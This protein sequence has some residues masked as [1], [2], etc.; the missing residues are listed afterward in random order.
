M[1]KTCL[2]RH[3]CSSPALAQSHTC[4]RW[5]HFWENRH[6]FAV[7]PGVRHERVI[8]VSDVGFR[9]LITFLSLGEPSTRRCLNRL[10][11]QD[12]EFWRQTK[13]ENLPVRKQRQAIYYLP[14]YNRVPPCFQSCGD[15]CAEGL[16]QE[17]AF[18]RNS[19]KG[20]KTQSDNYVVSS[21][22][23]L[24]HLPHPQQELK[25]KLP[26]KLGVSKLSQPEFPEGRTWAKVSVVPFYEEGANSGHL[27]D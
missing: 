26:L 17:N 24:P 14:L 15:V 22:L 4:P 1:L 2:L 5:L 8:S 19:F 21:L 27:P 25:V 20:D 18:P 13:S 10:D 6:G 12:S 7:P 11:S 3:T 9:R 16:E 23:L